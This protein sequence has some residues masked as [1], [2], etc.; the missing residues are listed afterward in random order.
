M[1]NLKFDIKK[2]TEPINFNRGDEKILIAGS[3]H[4]GEDEIILGVFQ[5]FKKMIFQAF[6]LMIAPR[7]LDRVDSIVELIK[8]ST[9]QGISTNGVNTDSISGLNGTLGLREQILER[10]T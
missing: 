5:S 7:H 3:T 6:K 2:N 4:K 10:M 1:K 9:A 8:T